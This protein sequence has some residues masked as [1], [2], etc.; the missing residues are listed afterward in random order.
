M[1]LDA[2]WLSQEELKTP[3]LFWTAQIRRTYVAL[4][5]IQNMFYNIKIHNRCNFD[6]NRMIRNKDIAL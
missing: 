5:Y 6:E 4:K 2:D 3:D 1:L